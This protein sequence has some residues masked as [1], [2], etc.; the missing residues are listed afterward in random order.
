MQRIRAIL[1]DLD[2]TLSDFMRMKEEACKAAV[3]AMVA[4][5]LRM[6]EKEAYSQL[7]ETYFELGLESDIAFAEFLRSSG[8]FNHKILAAAIN[9]YLETKSN[10]VKPYPSVKSVLRRLQNQGV[11]LGIITD[12]PKTKAYQRLLK[13]DIEPYFRFVIGFEDTD[14]KK[15][16]GLPFKLALSK[17]KNEIP[18]IKES[19]ILV[20]GDSIER[21]IRP[22]RQFGLRTALAKYGQRTLETR[23]AD[24]ELSRIKELEDVVKSFEQ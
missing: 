7:M 9:A 3:Q 24:Y 17:L 5:G 22:A 20:V 2:N 14:S 23:I 6:T 21:D 12:A 19:E 8:E 4:A 10:F 11:V 15:Q 1:F 16:T 18:D 13:M